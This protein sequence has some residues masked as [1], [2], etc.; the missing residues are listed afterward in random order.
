MRDVERNPELSPGPFLSWEKKP[1]SFI[2]VV[3]VSFS[4]PQPNRVL[5]EKVFGILSK[6]K[7]D[8][9]TYYY[10]LFMKIRSTLYEPGWT[11]DGLQTSQ[12][13]TSVQ[14]DDVATDPSYRNAG[15][16]GPVVDPG[17]PDSGQPEGRNPTRVGKRADT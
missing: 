7:R 3:W 15:E 8:C 13:W 5:V 4:G 2:K 9:K 14:D 17:P 16:K 1:E 10:K 6:N 12:N 11:S